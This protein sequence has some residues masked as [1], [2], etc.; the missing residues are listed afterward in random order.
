LRQALPERGSRH[1]LGPLP[2]DGLLDRHRIFA[3]TE[4]FHRF[5]TLPLVESNEVFR[6]AVRRLADGRFSFPE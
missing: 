4:A 6:D 5:M 1:Q 2:E 3:E